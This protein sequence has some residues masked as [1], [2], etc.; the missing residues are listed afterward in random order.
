MPK[1][2]ELDD[3]YTTVVPSTLGIQEVFG[4]SSGIEQKFRKDQPDPYSQAETEI[5]SAAEAQKNSL[6]SWTSENKRL[7]DQLQSINIPSPKKLPQLQPAPYQEFGNP[8]EN[9]GPVILFSA[10]MG[11]FTKAPL[12]TVINSSAEYMKGYHE[13]DQERMKL[14]RQNWLDSTNFALE[15]ARLEM[16]AYAMAMRTSQGKIDKL[17]AEMGAVAAEKRNDIMKAKID[18]GMWEDI[19]QMQNDRLKVYDS[20][21]KERDK[22][23]LEVRKQEET[24][25]YHRELADSRGKAKSAKQEEAQGR[26]DS[27]VNQID[28]AIQLIEKHKGESPVGLGGAYRRGKEFLFGGGSDFSEFQQII[29]TIQTQVPRAL[30]G[31]SRIAKDERARLDTI[32][33]GL[34]VLTNTEE[35]YN[36]LK[37]LKNILSRKDIIQV[38]TGDDLGS[39]TRQEIEDELRRR[40]E[41]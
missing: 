6:E 22:V 25:R 11:A 9:I 23:A 14:A 1:T 30:T 4:P 20:L 13:G 12:A 29:R 18:Q 28:R 34:G 38:E 41:L 8:M 15:Q 19:Y 2:S 35:T 31:T 36:N 33:P 39:A 16:D 37:V 21:R 27:V 26:V 24:E 7:R 5:R 10:L 17:Q 32:V 3:T 40:G